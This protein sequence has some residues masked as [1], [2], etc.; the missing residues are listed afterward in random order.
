MASFLVQAGLLGWKARLEDADNS[1]GLCS[2]FACGLGSVEM[3]V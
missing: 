2:W 3:R 1:L